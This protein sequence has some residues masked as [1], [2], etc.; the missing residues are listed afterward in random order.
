MSPVNAHL[1]TAGIGTARRRNWSIAMKIVLTMPYVVP[2]M[3]QMFSL[4]R[5]LSGET[6]ANGRR[7]G[8]EQT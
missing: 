2:G 7:G 8:T 5:F 4:P 1:E 6:S 3:W